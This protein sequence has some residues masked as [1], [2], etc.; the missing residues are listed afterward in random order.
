[1]DEKFSR[2]LNMIRKKK[3]AENNNEQNTKNNSTIKK[4]DKINQIRKMLEQRI[5]G[6]KKENENENLNNK[7]AKTNETNEINFLNLMEG[8]PLNTNKKRPTM[9]INFEEES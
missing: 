2:A 8:K 4:S 3:L 9:R 6:G 5:T 7:E 1:M